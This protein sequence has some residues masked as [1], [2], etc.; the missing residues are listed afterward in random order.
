M[1]LYE[2][3]SQQCHVI[4]DVIYHRLSLLKSEPPTS[5]FKRAEHVTT[6]SDFVVITVKMR[7]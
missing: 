4:G 1:R 2:R 7:D 3:V 5:D 6:A